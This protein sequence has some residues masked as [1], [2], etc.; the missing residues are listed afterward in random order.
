MPPHRCE[1]KPDKHAE[2]LCNASHGSPGPDHAFPN[3]IPAISA[4]VERQ[5]TGSFTGKNAFAYLCDNLAFFQIDQFFLTDSKLLT[6]VC[7]KAG[8][9]VPPRPFGAD[10]GRPIGQ[11]AGFAARNTASILYATLFAAGAESDLQLNVMCAHAPD[12]IVNLDAEQLNGTLVES[13]LCDIKTPLQIDEAQ[14]KILSWTSRLYITVLEN[15]GDTPDWL[16]WLCENLDTEGMNS[17]GLVGWGS[18]QSVCDDARSGGPPDE[19]VL[20]IGIP[21][22]GTNGA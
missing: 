2:S 16:G 6:A 4:I 21:C 1:V 13:T 18:K 19:L 8:K 22:N 10:A 17:V 5:L 9:Q 7:G 11:S 14:S 3:S 12:H 20:P 15:I